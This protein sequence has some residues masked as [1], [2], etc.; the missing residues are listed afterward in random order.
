MFIAGCPR[1]GTSALTELMSSLSN[2]ALGMERYK[3]KY[4]RKNAII[5]K[6]DFNKDNFFA[7]SSED[8]NI[9]NKSGKYVNYYKDLAEKYDGCNVRGDKYPHIFSFYDKISKGFDSDLK[10]IFIYRELVDV[11]SSFNVRASNENDKWPLENDYR[12]A[13]E[14]WNKSIEKTID[15]KRKKPNSLFI[16]K[17]EEMFDP[18]FNLQQDI[19]VKI[20]KYLSINNSEEFMEV[21]G[22]LSEKY[23][24]SV[25]NKSKS[26]DDNQ[27]DYLNKMKNFDAYRQLEA[28]K[29]EQFKN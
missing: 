1:S 7:F 3:F 14:L 12:K 18:S 16:V 10:F 26:L 20:C 28:L 25:K 9:D 24:S 2:V 11:A 19:S 6:N 5:N 17:Y 8:T 29:N 27:I 13:V 21:L 4:S 22:R 15:F 23:V